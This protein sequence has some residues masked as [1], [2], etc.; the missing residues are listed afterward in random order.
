MSRMDR[1][2]YVFCTGAGTVQFWTGAGTVQFLPGPVQSSFGPAGPGTM[3]EPDQTLDIM[4]TF[5]VKYAV[6]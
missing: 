3:P 6:L 5:F 4:K 1:R 2:R